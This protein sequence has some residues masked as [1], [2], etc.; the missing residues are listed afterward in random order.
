MFT[1]IKILHQLPFLRIFLF[2]ILGIGLASV[3]LDVNLGL[4]LIII[5]LCIGLICTYLPPNKSYI[6]G[7]VILFSVMALGYYSATIENPIKFYENPIKTYAEKVNENI[8]NILSEHLNKESSSICKA[9]CIADK[10]NLSSSIKK[11]FSRAGASHILAVS[12][13]HVGII[14]TAISTLLGFISKSRKFAFISGIISIGFLWFYAFICGLQPSIIRACTM[15]S[16]PILGKIFKRDNVSF[17]SLLFAAFCMVVY[18]YTYLFNIGFQLSFLAVA[19]ILFFQEKIF[20]ILN[21][22]NKILIWIW[23]MTS[24]S[25][26]AQ[27]TTLP[28]TIYYFHNIPVLSLFSNLIVVP[29]S[30]LIIYFTGIFIP[31]HLGP[32]NNLIALI[33]NKLGHFLNSSVQYFSNTSFAVIDNI[34]ISVFQVITCYVSIL[35]I[36]YFISE[37]KPSTLMWIIGMFI[38]FLAYD[39]IRLLFL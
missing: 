35:L 29:I 7:F 31:F 2:L 25:I 33:I 15:F 19:G 24:V 32:L 21:L 16:I 12:G 13:M 10:S 39:I 11:D 17:N 20:N 30:T 5:A 8:G 9:L 34:K 1:P 26:A 18:D 14:F 37:K 22:Q 38:L 6:K 3:N 28:L 23:S 27:I 4:I 36:R